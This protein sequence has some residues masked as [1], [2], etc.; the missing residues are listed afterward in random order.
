M[1]P[2]NIKIV[3][4]KKGETKEEAIERIRTDDK[5]EKPGTELKFE[6][7][8][9][10]PKAEKSNP[11][12]NEEMA[13]MSQDMMSEMKKDKEDKPSEKPLQVAV[14]DA[15][16]SDGLKAE[17]S[18]VKIESMKGGMEETVPEGTII[19]NPVGMTLSV[20]DMPIDFVPV[21]RFVSQ[22]M[23]EVTPIL[24]RVRLG[25][26]MEIGDI[27]TRAKQDKAQWDLYMQVMK[28]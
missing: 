15:K 22:V 7:P 1:P 19:D 6:D 23:A 25:M 26:T 13:K 24:S 5:P 4:N 21:N 9:T 18:D 20:P 2:K 3:R 10:P 12:D 11:K 16:D 14:D 27:S 17:E 8:D 28:M